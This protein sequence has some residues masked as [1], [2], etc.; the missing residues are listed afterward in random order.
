MLHL[1]RIIVKTSVTSQF[2]TVFY[3][4]VLCLSVWPLNVAFEPGLAYLPLLIRNIYLQA[5]SLHCSLDKL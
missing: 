4:A 3:G 1:S 5:T 2:Y